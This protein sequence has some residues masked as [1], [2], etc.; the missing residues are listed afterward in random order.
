MRVLTRPGS[1]VMKQAAGN[2]PG[3]ASPPP[4]VALIM[5]LIVLSILAMIGTPFVISM[6]HQDRESVNFAGGTVARLAAESAR[7]H[8][9]AGLEETVRGV[10]FEQEAE[11]LEEERPAWITDTG[12]GRS[13]STLR[14][15]R[16]LRGSPG[17]R[18]GT[19][20]R[21]DRGERSPRRDNR[22]CAP[23]GR[24]AR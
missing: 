12:P 23:E 18:S 17:A 16:S 13:R 2:K 20:I 4:G 7:N 8:V 14:G 6:A 9:V 15:G 1:V 21:R 24:P 11:L 10:E 3:V 22:R 19:V 5:V